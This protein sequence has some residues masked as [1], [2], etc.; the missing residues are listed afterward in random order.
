MVATTKQ[1]AYGAGVMTVLQDVM[2]VSDMWII[3]SSVHEVLLIDKSTMDEDDL[4][5][6]ITAINMS[7]VD[8]KDRLSDHPHDGATLE[9]VNIA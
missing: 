8:V 6:M 1:G 5:T 3:P 2:D 4:C 9:G 7:E